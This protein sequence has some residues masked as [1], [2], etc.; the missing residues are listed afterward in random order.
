MKSEG[1]SFSCGQSLPWMMRF[2][3]LFLISLISSVCSASIDSLKHLIATEQNDSV[4]VDL[5][6][7][8]SKEYFDVS[9]DT[10]IV[11]ATQAKD[12]AQKIGYKKGEAYAWKHI[13]LAN[14]FLS[15]YV[16]AIPAYEQSLAIFESI[17]D[18]VGVS[19]INN[20]IGV[21]F[22]EQRDDVTAMD[23]YLKS[24][25]G[26]EEANDT[27]R[28]L[29][30]LMN[31]GETYAFKKHTYNKALE[32]YKRALSLSEASSDSE[33]VQ[34]TA[35]NLGELYF[36][37]F[38]ESP[39]VAYLDT[40]RRY[41]ERSLKSFED[42]LRI[43]G[44]LN[45]LGK[46]YLRLKDPATAIKWH[47]Q[48]LEFSKRMD[49]KLEMAQ[50]LLGIADA[51]R[52]SGH[53]T[54]SLVFYRQAEEILSHLEVGEDLKN[55]YKEMSLAYAEQS[56]FMNAFKYQ[57]LLAAVKDSLYRLDTDQKLQG[58]AFHF[59]LEKKENA[60]KIQE[61]EIE[62]QKLVRNGF[63]GGFALMLMFA[64]VFFTQ[65]NRI[66]KEKKRSDE[67][68]LNI[69]PEETAEELK[70]TGSAKAKSFD[71]V[72][73]LFTDF[74]NFTQAS[75]KLGAEE[76]V[77][78][79]N[80]CF[81]EFDRIVTKHGV[82]KIKTIGDAY[83]CAGGLPVATTT[84][85]HDVIKAGLEMQQF[86]EKNKQERI[87][88]GEPYFELRLG[89]HTG[90]VVAGIVGIKKFAYDIWGDT[91]N[92]ASR[93]ESSG[94]VGKVNISDATYQMVKGQFKCVHRG[95]V[96]AKNK[97]EIDMYFVEGLN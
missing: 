78:E 35:I 81:S 45:Y 83:M 13:G 30:A 25:K 6:N 74:K 20:N 94:E 43:T 88:K 73:V 3:I 82:E 54:E 84:H 80:Y 2:A 34:I 23:Y 40:S 92:T 90:P 97:G 62:Q 21:I 70:A 56:D 50:S 85:A 12:L 95:K 72:T 9:N 16:E 63:I 86:I 28:I 89:V 51:K 48:A 39:Q 27:L 57:N 52:Q 36:K 22:A 7:T 59:D 47:E 5:L 24:L 96:Q 93:M 68:L 64:A 32:N 58:L 10:A 60:I 15:H 14:Y 41:L 33:S 75:E 17:N 49:F 69:L 37:K 53:V 8:L 38:D 71:T 67:L 44:A 46:V 91:V 29:T 55:I 18:K 76:L 4:K 19:N 65:R 61:Q 87:A 42:S 11:V 66:S 79:I 26:G 77:K 1:F 31:I